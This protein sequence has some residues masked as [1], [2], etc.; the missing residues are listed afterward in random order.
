MNLHGCVARWIG[1][2][3]AR[4]SSVTFLTSFLFALRFVRRNHRRPP[5]TACMEMLEGSFEVLS[6]MIGGPS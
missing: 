4:S 5:A 6:G 2:S 1:Q 3:V